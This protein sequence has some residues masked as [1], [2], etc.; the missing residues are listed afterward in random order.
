[1]DLTLYVGIDVAKSTLQYHGLTN[2]K[3][4]DKL[5]AGKVLNRPAGAEKIIQKILTANK[6]Q[7]FSAIKIG[8]EATSVYNILPAHYFNT[9]LDLLHLQNVEIITLNPKQTHRFSEIYDDDKNDKLD[10]NHIAEFLLLGKYKTAEPRDEIHLALQRL[11]R[12]R[13]QIIKET[14]QVKNRFLNNL[15]LKV[16]A[17]SDE[18]PT[19]VFGETML[20]LL[21][22]ERYS[23]DDIAIMPM[24]ELI[25]EI[26]TLSRKSFSDVET[27]ATA[28][29][30]AI[31]DSYQIG[32]IMMDSLN[33]VL[34]LYAN[35]LRLFKK[36]LVQ[37]EKTIANLC[38]LLPEAK[39]LKTIPG[40]GPV[41]M[42]GIVAEIGQINRFDKEAKLAKYA[43]LT[44]KTRQSGS[45]TVQATPRVKSGDNYLRYYLVEA[46]D[47]VRKYDPA[48]KQFYKKKFEEVPKYQHRRA[49]VMTARKLCR[50]VYTMLKN[51]AAYT[52][53]KVV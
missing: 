38:D 35:E 23:L 16:N 19:P 21:C 27:I 14:M 3:P 31:T 34:A 8:L 45:T 26:N 46:A 29:K 5:F 53:A 9:D 6:E 33:T 32:T 48:F 17:V 1:M 28:L 18:V 7:H 47:S 24:E 11:T 2:E 40:I 10:A 25:D 22:D 49:C 30:Q 42:A 15:Y 51:N 13:Y 44:W 12:T 52:P 20:T 39:K 43:G 4:E 36:Q 50:V 41:Y 37:V